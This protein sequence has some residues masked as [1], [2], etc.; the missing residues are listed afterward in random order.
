MSRPKSSRSIAADIAKSY[1]ENMKL[2]LDSM[3]GLDHKSRAYLDRLVAKAKLEQSFR[4][5][6]SRR[7]LDPQN[8]GTV[9]QLRY[10][11]TAIVDPQQ[12]ELNAGR[13]QF[14]NSMDEEFSSPGLPKPE[15]APEPKKSKKRKK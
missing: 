7:G 8:L 11:F 2:L 15:P 6:R 3:K 10:D 12:Y 13:Q 1:R 14:E 4:D 5:E 9:T